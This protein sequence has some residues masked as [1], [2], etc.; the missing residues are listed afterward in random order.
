MKLYSIS[1]EYVKYLRTF[2][3]KVYDNKE[4]IRKNTRKYIEYMKIKR[5]N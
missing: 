2:D 4:E 1:D 5:E 3:K